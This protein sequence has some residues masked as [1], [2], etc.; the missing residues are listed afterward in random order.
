MQF[1]VACKGGVLIAPAWDMN[2][3]LP[4]ST[5]NFRLLVMDISIRKQKPCG[6][7]TI[8]LYYQSIEHAL[9]ASVYLNLKCTVQRFVHYYNVLFS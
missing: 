1:S 5:V 3:C 2:L 7:G 4:T 9:M 6:G 8:E